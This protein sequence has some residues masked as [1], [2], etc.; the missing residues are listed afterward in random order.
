MEIITFLKAYVGKSYSVFT[1]LCSI[2]GFVALFVKNETACIIALSVFCLC[3]LLLLYSVFLALRK[4]IIDHSDHEYRGIS[5]FYTFE[6]KDGRNSTFE[7]YRL[8]QCKRPFLTSIK[9][10]FKWSGTIQPSITSS[11]QKIRNISHTEDKESWDEAEII[12]NHPLRYNESTVVHVM[13]T[14]DDY[15][16]HAKPWLSCKLERPIEMMVYRILLPYKPEGYNQ[17][18]VFERKKIGTQIDGEY[19]YIE[20]IPF[21]NGNK[22]YSHCVVNPE[23][24]YIYRLRWEK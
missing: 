5:S 16:G 15:D 19:Q 9:Y 10:N 1:S 8:I 12:F 2:A 22:Q 6:C 7:V 17:S 11:T 23:P 24:G 18:A 20:S 4:L 21:N 3:L 14:N 13:T